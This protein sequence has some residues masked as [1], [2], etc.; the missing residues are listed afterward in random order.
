M[1]RP[2]STAIDD[3][4]EDLSN[5]LHLIKQE[6]KQCFIMG[7]ININLLNVDT[8][9]RTAQFLETMYSYSF[10]P[11][12][13]KP[14]RVTSNSATL[15]DNIFTNNQFSQ[16][17]LQGILSIDVSD[18]F[19]VFFI[20]LVNSLPHCEKFY[21]R[22]CFTN[23]NRE[24][25]KRTLL[26]TKWSDVLENNCAQ[27]SFSAFHRIIKHAYDSCF[28]VKISKSNYKNKFKWLTTGLKKC[29]KVK[30]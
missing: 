10:T 30:N 5:I 26:N 22:R 27:G 16:A 24:K 8:H 29:I 4:T 11:L 15:I 21:R 17:S 2:P 6:S 9:P 23:S 3:F 1:Y 20:D 12:I 7:D 25:F 18:H 14:T 13:T 28:P 19:P